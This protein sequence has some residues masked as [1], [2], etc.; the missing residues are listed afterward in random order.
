MTDPAKMGMTVRHLE[1]KSAVKLS[2]I[3][4]MAKF[5]EISRAVRVFSDQVKVDENEITIHMG[6]PLAKDM[7]VELLSRSPLVAFLGEA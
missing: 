1:N 7:F 6:Y 3:G 5:E 4:D 2:F